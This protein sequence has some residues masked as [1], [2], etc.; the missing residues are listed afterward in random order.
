MCK[1]QKEKTRKEMEENE[2]KGELSVT[3]ALIL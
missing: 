1:T 2:M 3:M